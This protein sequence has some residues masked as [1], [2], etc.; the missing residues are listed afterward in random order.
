MYYKKLVI[1]EGTAK[2]GLF[3]TTKDTIMKSRE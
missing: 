2:T 1:D 3:F